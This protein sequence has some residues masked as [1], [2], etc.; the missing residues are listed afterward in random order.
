MCAM[1]F[2]G[3]CFK[4]IVLIQS[5]PGVEF[6]S[7]VVASITFPIVISKLFGGRVC[8]L[9]KKGWFCMNDSVSCRC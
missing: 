9:N 7:L 3:I 1:V 8:G 2:E 5:G 4:M 6:F